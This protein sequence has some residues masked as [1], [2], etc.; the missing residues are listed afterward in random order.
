[1]SDAQEDEPEEGASPRNQLVCGAGQTIVEQGDPSHNAFYLEEGRAEVMI[2]DG[3]H[4]IKISEILPGEI[5]GE[6]GLIEE[7]NRMASVRAID[8]CILTVIPREEIHERINNIDDK[9]IKSVIDVLLKRLRA[10]N[11]GQVRYYK[12]LARFQDRM[13]GLMQKASHENIDQ[14]KRDQFSTTVIPLLDQLDELL[15]QYRK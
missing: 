15:D 11:Q 5:F 8:K 9:I 3:D 14:T 4:M 1:M 6:M 12:D 7:E 10:A 13:A 2:R